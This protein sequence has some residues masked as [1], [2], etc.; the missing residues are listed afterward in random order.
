MNVA[1]INVISFNV[2]GMMASTS[3]DVMFRCCDDCASGD[4]GECDHYNHYTLYLC[5]HGT[6]GDA[7]L[8]GVSRGRLQLTCALLLG[9]SRGGESPGVLL[10]LRS[11]R[12]GR[13]CCSEEFISSRAGFILALL[14]GVAGR[15]GGVRWRVSRAKC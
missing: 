12:L 10:L 11:A 15:E 2:P 4:M 7:L 13:V 1:R 8:L 6:C 3:V 9:V 14:L 5:S